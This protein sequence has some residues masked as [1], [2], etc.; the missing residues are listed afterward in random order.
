MKLF[1]LAIVTLATAS[2]FAKSNNE[3]YFQPAAG[4]SAVELSY[5]MDVKP[6]KNETAGVET[7][8]KQ[9]MSDFYLNYAYG[10]NENNA[11]GAETFFGSNKMTDGT[12][13]HTADGMGDIHLFYKGFT[14][15]WHYGADFGINTEKIKIDTVSTLQ[16]NR[17]SG[18][19]SLKANVGLLMNSDALNYGADLS[20]TMP[21]ERSVDMT[22]EVKLTGGN[23]LKLAPFLEYNWGMGFIGGE[24]SYNMVDDL[25]S[26]VSGVTS[27]FMKGESFM[28][29]NLY[30]TFDFNETFTGLL[31]LGMNM[32]QEHDTATAGTKAKAYTE[33]IAKLGVRMSF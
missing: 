9:E 8:N 20:Y 11:I 28:G 5:Q 14:G 27:T 10:L 16:D 4:A 30:G 3:Y 6:A 19:M 13:T 2:A 24:L 31:D 33:T 15:M 21:M 29:L 22:P 23:M 7:D 25:K 17:S 12:T 1:T 32:H 18:G 26:K